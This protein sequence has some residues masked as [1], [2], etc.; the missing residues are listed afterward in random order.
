MEQGSEKKKN[1]PG[2][3]EP[4]GDGCINRDEFGLANM[5]VIF[6]G[7]LVDRTIMPH[8]VRREIAQFQQSSFG[9]ID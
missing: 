7:S 9:K 8:S 2:K 4:T 3:S 5:V 6:D 1:I